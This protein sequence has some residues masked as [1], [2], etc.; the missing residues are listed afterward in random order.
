M[1]VDARPPLYIPGPLSLSTSKSPGTP[2]SV[3]T[4]NAKVTAKITILSPS[5]PHLNVRTHYKG[6][7]QI[8]QNHKWQGV[9]E[10]NKFWRIRIQKQEILTTECYTSYEGHMDLWKRNGL[11]SC[12]LTSR[13]V[14][15]AA[16]RPLQSCALTYWGKFS[17]KIFS[18]IFC[19]YEHKWFLK[20]YF[21]YDCE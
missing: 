21:Q 10:L 5:T 20:R 8:H 9:P 13:W 4:H 1:Y 2:R 18:L 15:S 11:P 7:F 16:H 17:N 14:T 19:N 6:H 3:L 12:H